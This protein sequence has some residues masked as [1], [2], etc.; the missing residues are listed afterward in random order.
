[1][2]DHKNKTMTTEAE[3]FGMV[4][5]ASRSS[6]GQSQGVSAVSR[7][8]GI[9]ELAE[10]ILGDLPLGDLVLL[11]N[12]CDT[13]LSTIE[14]S[15][16]I[17]K[18]VEAECYSPTLAWVEN[19]ENGWSKEIR[20]DARFVAFLAGRDSWAKVFLARKGECEAVAVVFSGERTQLKIVDGFKVK[21]EWRRM[22]AMRWTVAIYDTE[23]G[24]TV[25]RDLRPLAS[26][27]ES[28]ALRYLIKFHGGVGY[29]QSDRIS[30]GAS[31]IYGV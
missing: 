13:I 4:P 23:L 19:R 9:F 28:I 15:T 3:D 11:A 5:Y 29:E 1:M 18:R 12:T 7:V 2:A 22:D 24:R 10:Q 30:I 8:F 21:I 20:Y 31:F 27:S 6:P 14:N 25:A 17:A 26:C 16:H